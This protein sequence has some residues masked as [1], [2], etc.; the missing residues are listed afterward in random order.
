MKSIEGIIPVMLTPFTAEGSVDYPALKRLVEWYIAHQVDGLFAV[1]Q[2]SEMQ[3]LT[4]DER[5]NITKCV[6][7]QVA[8]R[9]PVMASGHISD[10]LETQINELQAMSECGSDVLVLVT[11]HLD[12]ENKGSDVFYE[13]LN[14]LMAQLPKELPLGLYECPAPYRRLLTDEE[15]Q[16][17]ANSGRFVALKD[18]SC[19]L[20]TVTRRVSLV[21]DTPLHIINANAAIAYPAIQAGS[22]GFCG[23]FT[24]FHPELYHWLY[25]QHNDDPTLADELSIFLSL[26]AVVEN[27]GY[28]KNAKIYHQL[29]GN[30]NFNSDY[31]R[32]IKDDVVEKYW[33]LDVLLNQIKQGTNIYLN[34]INKL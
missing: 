28:P 10:D 32:T 8:G 33:A 17:C 14:T 16:F 15:L 3:F 25:H 20:A 2:S 5:I 21:K 26:S 12:P 4:L 23:V 30:N 6:V 27:L 9:I 31:C 13:Y 18:V 29:L 19:D 7:E 34:K 24:N 22:K 1:C 11:N